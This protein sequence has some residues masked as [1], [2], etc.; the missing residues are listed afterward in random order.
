MRG[1]EE[2]AFPAEERPFCV[3]VDLTLRDPLK[4]VDIMLIIGRKYLE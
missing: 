1:V 2:L 4:L 3:P